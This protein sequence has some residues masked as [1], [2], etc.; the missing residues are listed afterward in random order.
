V[1]VP[2]GRILPPIPA[3]GFQSDGELA[4]LPGARK[5][6][7]QALSPGPT[8]DVYAFYRGTSQRN[9]YRIPIL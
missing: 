1:P 6:E 4:R 7:A 3:G 8:A 2:P 9:L 5:V